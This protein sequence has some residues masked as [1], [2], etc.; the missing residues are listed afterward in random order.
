MFIGNLLAQWQEALFNKKQ[1]GSVFLLFIFL[2]T[3]HWNKLFFCIFLDCLQMMTH[4]LLGYS[5]ENG[6]RNY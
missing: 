5:Y 3:I 1:S 2:G 6:L 4:F